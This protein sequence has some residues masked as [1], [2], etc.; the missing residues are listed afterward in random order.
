MLKQYYASGEFVSARDL[1]KAMLIEVIPKSSDEVI[2]YCPALQMGLMSVFPA[3]D[4]YDSKYRNLKLSE[5]NKLKP[6]LPWLHSTD[7]QDPGAVLEII[8]E[9][10]VSWKSQSLGEM[11]S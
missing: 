8:R 2:Q 10:K 1:D 3:I 7:W 5:S 9:A 4:K 11:K 6:W